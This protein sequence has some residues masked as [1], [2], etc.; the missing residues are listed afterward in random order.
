MRCPGKAALVRRSS[1]S[2]VFSGF[3]ALH[4][5]LAKIPCPPMHPLSKQA[6][7]RQHAFDRGCDSRRAADMPPGLRPEDTSPPKQGPDVNPMKTDSLRKPR[8]IRGRAGHSSPGD[9]P[10]RCR[11]VE[12]FEDAAARYAREGAHARAAKAARGARQ[13][14]GARQEL[15]GTAEQPQ[16]RK[17]VFASALKRVTERSIACKSSRCAPR[18]SRRH[19]RRSRCTEPGSSRIDRPRARRRERRCVQR[20]VRAGATWCRPR[21]SAASCG[22][23]RWRRQ[24]ATRGLS[25]LRVEIVGAA[26]VERHGAE[27]SADRSRIDRAA[28]NGARPLV[29][30]PR[31]ADRGG[32]DKNGTIAL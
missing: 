2:P 27:C 14:R 10:K 3:P 26:R 25:V 24:S 8:R 9:L 30:V 11:G 12:I 1:K 29:R 21:R 19:T 31:R 15:S 4:L 28:F 23:P 7:R 20:S 18:T 13:G 32:G 6:P 22:R 16:R 5:V 17:Q